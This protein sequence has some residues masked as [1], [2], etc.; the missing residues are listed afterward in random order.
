MA[1]TI[2]R[3][4]NQLPDLLEFVRTL[5][6]QIE[7]AAIQ[8]GEA[9]VARMRHFYTAEQMAAIEPVAPGWREMAAYADGTTLHHVTQVLIALQ[10]LPEYRRASQYL[11]ALMEWSVLYHDLG[12][13]VIAGQ[14]DALHA[15]RS[16]G[17]AART[18]PRLGFLTSEAYPATLEPWSQLVLGAS[19]ATP[20]GKGSMQDNRAL[21]EILRGIDQLFGTGSA[22]TLIVQAAL[23]H[24]SLNVVPEWPNPGSLT[25]AQVPA[26]IRPELIPLLEGLMLADSDAWQLFEPDKKAKFRESTLA[27]F[28]AVREMVAV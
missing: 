11:Q 1:A 14:R 12:K 9:L 10:L 20:D 18:L 4:E 7:T 22:A 3:L 21:P 8:D 5:A 16:A 15:F 27:V 25:E 6:W 24:Q 23:L 17:M 26:C 28:A 19:V 13:Q 2:P